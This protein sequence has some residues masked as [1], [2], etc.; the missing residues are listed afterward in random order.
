M[1]DLHVTKYKELRGKLTQQAAAAKT[2]I[3][4]SRARRLESG[5]RGAAAA[6]A[7]AALAHARRRATAF[8]SGAHGRSAATVSYL[9]HL[10]VA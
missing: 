1:T 4:M 6:P 3:S 2:D 7:I 5:R 10:A 8:Q 9:S